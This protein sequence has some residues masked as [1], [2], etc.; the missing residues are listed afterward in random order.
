MYFNPL[1]D[2]DYLTVGPTEVDLHA[3]CQKQAWTDALV[4]K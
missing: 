2:L 1:E 3:A 4:L